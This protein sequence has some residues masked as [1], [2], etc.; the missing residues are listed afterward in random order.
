MEGFMKRTFLPILL[1]LCLIPTAAFA[2]PALSLRRTRRIL[3]WC[4][5]VLMWYLDTTHVEP[6]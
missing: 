3:L 2:H 5:D 4:V 6:G 1:G